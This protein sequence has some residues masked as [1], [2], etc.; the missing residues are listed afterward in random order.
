[1]NELLNKLS[2]YNIFNYLFPGAIFSILAD[3]FHI[4][5]SPNDIIRQLLWYYFAGMVISRIGS[6]IL[7]PILRR[8]SFVRYSDYSKYLRACSLDP[9]LDLMVEVSNT[10]RTLATAFVIL[11]LGVFLDRI[12]KA[13]D[14]PVFW[15]NA[16]A[17]LLLSVL[18]LFSF[19]KQS[20]YVTKRVNHN[21]GA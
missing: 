19:K 5:D 3:R 2:S 8:A 18:F 16:V 7:E 10:Y 14:M 17:L 13:F 21:G 15:M 11:F 20:D 4:L 1:M 12:A 9:K 6:V